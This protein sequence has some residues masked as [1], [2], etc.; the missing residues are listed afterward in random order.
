[1]FF[2]LEDSLTFVVPY[3]ELYTR[4][5]RNF[6]VST[7]IRK[8]DPVKM[9]YNIKIR[10]CDTEGPSAPQA[11]MRLRQWLCMCEPDMGSFFFFFNFF[12]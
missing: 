11:L 5:V 7:S 2:R 1:M 10:R 3:I 4:K 9:S 12:Y 6:L 8:S